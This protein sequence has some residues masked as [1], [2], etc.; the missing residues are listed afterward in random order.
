MTTDSQSQIASPAT[1]PVDRIESIDVLRGVAVLGIL[2]INIWIFAFPFDVGQNPTLWGEYFGADVVAWWISWVAI[3]GSQ[4]AIFTVLFGAS[5]YL[6]ISRLSSDDRRNIVGRIYYRRTF[7]LIVFGLVNGYILLWE[8]DILFFYGVMGLLLYLMCNW[9]IRNLI[10]VGLVILVLL[11][12]FKETGNWVERT[13]GDTAA[14]A[15]EKL[16]QGQPLTDEEQMA[17]D[18][19]GDMIMSAKSHDELADQVEAR[20]NGYVSAFPNVAESTT[21]NYI[22]FGLVA[23]F[24]ESLAYMMLGMAFFRL[25]LFDA[26]RPLSL[27]LGMTVF[28]FAIG[29]GVNTWE[30]MVSVSNNYSSPITMWTYDIGRFAM[31]TGYT[32]LIMLICK[33]GWFSWFRRSFAAVGKMAL[34]N[35]IAHSIACLFIFIVF[36][37]YGE[38]RFH[39][40][41]YIVFVIWAIQIVVSPIWLKHYRYGPLEWVWRRLTYWQPVSFKQ[42]PVVA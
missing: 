19:A 7:W 11:A 20:K 36:G 24:W 4:R 22:V 32:G 6:F 37:Y 29:L 26:S 14:I 35:Y 23:L 40:I 42:K 3:E 31:A 1:D 16:D 28:G 39:Q 21:S 18:I 10:I 34:S 13:F 5:V 15:Q 38:L 8:G 41:Y 25:R 2:A 9:K 27:Y 12:A 17:F 30:M 33:L